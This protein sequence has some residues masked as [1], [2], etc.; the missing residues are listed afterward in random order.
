VQGTFTVDLRNRCR[1]VPKRLR[2]AVGYSC[3]AEN[4]TIPVR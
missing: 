2:R 1:P 4:G 3:D